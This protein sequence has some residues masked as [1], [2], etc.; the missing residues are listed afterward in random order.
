M[1]Q[2]TLILKNTRLYWSDL[3]QPAKDYKDEKTG[4]VTP[5]QYTATVIFDP[6]S[7]AGKLAQATFA[8]VAK[9]EFGPNFA[10]ILQA[11]D[12]KKKAIR[13][14]NHKLDKEGNIVEGFKDMLYLS[15]KNKQKPIVIDSFF[16]AGQPTPITE[17]SGRIYRGCMVNVKVE[18]SAFTSKISEVGRMVGAKI[19][20]VQFAGDG[21]AFGSPP[22]TADGF[23]DMGGAP[24]MSADAASMFN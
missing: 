21:E 3:F 6:N 23:G 19:L 8:E 2:K 15:A 5:G 7:E 11:I 22:P 16:T 17:D 13:N 9:E 24:E 12:P 18:I 1:A 20:A 10:T 4:R 14:G